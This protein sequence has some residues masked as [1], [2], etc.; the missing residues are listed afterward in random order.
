MK[1]LKTLWASPLAKVVISFVGL[2]VLLFSL[3]VVPLM[4]YFLGDDVPI[5]LYNAYREADQFNDFEYVE[6]G[7]QDLTKVPIEL[8]SLD[9]RNEYETDIDKFYQ[10]LNEGTFY[11]VIEVTNNTS[12]VIQVVEEEPDEGLYLEIDFLFLAIDPVRTD[13]KFEETGNY[14]PIYDGIQ[15]T[16]KNLISV[17]DSNVPN[18]YDRLK[19]ETIVVTLRIYRGQYIIINP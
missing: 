3:T 4:T 16:Y 10:R 11:A 6:V 12:R 13:E 17:L 18:M 1:N 7:I 14:E 8:L 15:I 5:T 9:L 19:T 2:F